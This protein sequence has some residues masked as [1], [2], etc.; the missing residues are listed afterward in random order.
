MPHWE[1]G[2]AEFLRGMEKPLGF[3]YVQKKNRKQ[4]SE[5]GYSA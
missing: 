4:K 2:R 1:S 3:A 5:G